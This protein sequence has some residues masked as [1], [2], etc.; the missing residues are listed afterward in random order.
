[1][2]RPATAATSA[3]CY[4]RESIHGKISHISYLV[5]GRNNYDVHSLHSAKCKNLKS[6]HPPENPPKNNPQTGKARELVSARSRIQ[7][8]FAPT[9]LPITIS[10]PPELP[11][12]P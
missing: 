11:I 1:M 6:A 12:W 3:R 7:S 10:T 9:T 4:A 8:H 5:C 2:P